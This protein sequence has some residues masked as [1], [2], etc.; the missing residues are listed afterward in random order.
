ME[1]ETVEKRLLGDDVCKQVYYLDENIHLVALLNGRGHV[2]DIVESENG[3]N[4]KLGT[5]KREMLFMGC[6]LESSMKKEYDNEF[7]TVSGSITQRENI[8][9]FSFPIGSYLILVMAK[10]LFN[11]SVFHEKISDIIFRKTS[12]RKIE[13]ALAS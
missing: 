1:I 9:L 12:L 10:P 13:N 8:V 5:A 3:L 11:L 6:V 7:G 2:E 4:K